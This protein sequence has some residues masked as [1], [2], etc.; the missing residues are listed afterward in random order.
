MTRCWNKSS[1]NFPKVAPD[2]EVLNLKSDVFKVTQKV[3]NTICATFAENILQEVS[4]TPNL[5]TLIGRGG[6]NKT[7]HGTVFLI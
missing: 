1:P 6:V 2:T 3:A 7:K 5:V 4:K